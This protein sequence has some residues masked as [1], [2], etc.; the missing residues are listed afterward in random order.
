MFCTYAD[1]EIFGRKGNRDPGPAVKALKL[2]NLFFIG[3]LISSRP[4]SRL[5]PRMIEYRDHTC[6]FM[7]KHLPGTED[8]V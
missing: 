1:S 6:V 5:D 7:H 3:D 8:V 4:P 2:I